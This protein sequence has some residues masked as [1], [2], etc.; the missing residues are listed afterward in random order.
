MKYSQKIAKNPRVLPW[1]FFQCFK[2]WLGE[3]KMKGYQLKI[4]GFELKTCQNIRNSIQ[5]ERN[6]IDNERN[7]IENA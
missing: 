4:K 2:M 6:L 7:S 5:N 1:N 3:S